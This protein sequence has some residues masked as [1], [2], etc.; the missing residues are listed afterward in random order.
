MFEFHRRRDE[1]MRR[2]AKKVLAGV[3]LASVGASIL[4]ALVV[5][6][7][8]DAECRRYGFQRSVVSVVGVFCKKIQGDTEYTSVLEEFKEKCRSTHSGSPECGR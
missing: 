5:K 1:T 4:W 2:R 8:S 7:K 6:V 3:V